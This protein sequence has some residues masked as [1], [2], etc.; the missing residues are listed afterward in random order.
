MRAY[1]AA[2]S[3]TATW[4]TI[5]DAAT[6]GQADKP[7]R[8]TTL[9]YRDV[10]ERLYLLDPV[11]GWRPTRSRLGR[12]TEPPKHQVADPALAMT[13]LGITE[14]QLLAG[15]GPGPPTPRDGP[16]L[17]ALF[18]SLV[19]LSVRVYAQV[20]RALVSHMR[21]YTG[22]HEVDLMVERR[23]GRVLAVEVKLTA[24]PEEDDVRQLTW[25]AERL[26]EDLLDAILVTTGKQA[27]RRSDG[28][29]VVPA[30]LLGP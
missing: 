30:A 11:P 10:L 1:A 14:E 26:G 8:S 15:E 28:I 17:G 6:S 9:P 29:A 5:R 24:A 25:L 16:F 3:T 23:D 18:E 21:T 7:A 27:Y 4:E 13:L 19:T 22:E 12:L 20:Q 2:T